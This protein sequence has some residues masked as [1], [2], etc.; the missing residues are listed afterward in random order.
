MLIV[1]LLRADP[2]E[3]PSPE[4]AL[5]DEFFTCGY[6]PPRLPTSCLTTAPRF[7]SVEQHV[8]LQ[9]K[10]LSLVNKGEKDVEVVKKANTELTNGKPAGPMGLG[11]S[12]RTPGVRMGEEP[13]P[14]E[15]D[16]LTVGT[17]GA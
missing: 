12:S 17:T 11:G 6:M 10:P 3:R 1:R 9:R 2:T 16:A 14:C 8:G 7:T 5:T 4:Q 13:S 15:F